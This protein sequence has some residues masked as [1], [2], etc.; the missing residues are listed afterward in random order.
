V[1]AVLSNSDTP[2]TRALF[3]RHR[4]ELVSVRRA[5]NSVATRRGGVDEILVSPRRV[6]RALRAVRARG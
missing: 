3:E 5:I 2:V 6:T 1:V 4:L